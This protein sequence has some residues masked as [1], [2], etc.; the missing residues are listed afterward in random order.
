VFREARWLQVTGIT[1]EGMSDGSS[2]AHM[3][4]ARIDKR[5]AG[6]LQLQANFQYS[7]VMQKLDRLN[8]SD[9][10]PVNRV[11]SN[12]RPLRLVTS[13][14][15]SL[16][17]GRGKRFLG[18]APGWLNQVAGGWLLSGVL[19]SQSGPPL[20]WG[21]AIY[22]GGDLHMDPTNIDRAFDTTRFNTNSKQQLGSDVRTFP[23]TFSNLR[24]AGIVSLDL[25][26]VKDFPIHERLKLQY[27]CEFFNAPNHPLFDAP[28][29]SPTSTTFGKIQNQTNLPRSI[30]MSL[31][32]AW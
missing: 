9:P 2:Y 21:D 20:E 8:D 5:F 24:A 11:A 27:R 19:V 18:G 26:A 32:L 22:L 30:Q 7:R 28:D 13:G 16:P 14:L 23:I 10:S 1:A 29:V 17:F 12:D 6:G 4:M 31:K 25:A 3:L 15:Y